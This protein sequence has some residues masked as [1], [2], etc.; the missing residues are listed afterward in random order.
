MSNL[1]P[2]ELRRALETVSYDG[3][4]IHRVIDREL[5]GFEFENAARAIKRGVENKFRNTFPIDAATEIVCKLLG[6]E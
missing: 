4:E 5:R 2:N 1:C 3:S 6:K